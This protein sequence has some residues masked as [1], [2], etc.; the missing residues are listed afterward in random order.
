MGVWVYWRHSIQRSSFLAE[1]ISLGGVM[2]LASAVGR[3]LAVLGLAVSLCGFP[4]SFGQPAQAAGSLAGRIFVADGVTP[5]PGVVVKVANLTTSKIFASALTDRSGR[6]VLGDLPSGQY[7]VAVDT[8]EGLY[9]NQERVPVLQGR[10]TLFSLALNRSAQDNP[11]DNPPP[12]PPPSEPPA[13]A[14]PP[15]EA[16]KPEETKPE[17]TKP[18]EK[19]PEEK[20]TPAEQEAAKK[21]KGGSFWRS[22]WGVA[23][24]LGGGAIVLGA[25]ASSIAGDNSSVPEPPSQST[26]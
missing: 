11:G 4:L 20:K 21:K 17:E 1:E 9:V 6:Y 3:R 2:R 13:P 25:L 12:P 18:E 5:R 7:Q 16:P 26:P 8:G 14:Q 22:G 15:P 19:K 10:K 24:G 23:V